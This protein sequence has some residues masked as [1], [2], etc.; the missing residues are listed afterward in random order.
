MR[1]RNGSFSWQLMQ[2]TEN[3]QLWIE[4]FFDESWLDHLRHHDRVTRAELKT[5][6][7]ARHFLLAGKSVRIRHL[8]K[9]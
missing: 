8:L 2:D 3:P 6:L 4:L 5:E 7:A 9:G 1:H